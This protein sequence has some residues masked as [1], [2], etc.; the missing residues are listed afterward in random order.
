VKIARRIAT[1]GFST[2]GTSPLPVRSISEERRIMETHNEGRAA[3]YAGVK[4]T[5]SPYGAGALRSLWVKGWYDAQHDRCATR[6]RDEGALF[7]GS[8]QTRLL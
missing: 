6:A 5:D 2:L 8:R 3:F 4:P 7:A 1:M